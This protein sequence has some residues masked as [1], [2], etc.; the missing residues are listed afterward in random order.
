VPFGG[1]YRLVGFALSNLANSD[2]RGIGIVGAGPDGR[3]VGSF[4]EKPADRPTIPDS[5]GESFASMGSYVLDTGDVAA[6]RTR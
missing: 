1:V 4:L 6:R 2:L 5:P 3:S